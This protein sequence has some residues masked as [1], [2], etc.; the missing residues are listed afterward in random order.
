M[1][2]RHCNPYNSKSNTVNNSANSSGEIIYNSNNSILIFF[3]TPVTLYLRF[4]LVGV[5]LFTHLNN[6]INKE[7]LFSD[8]LR[9]LTF[10][11]AIKIFEFRFSLELSEVYLAIVWQLDLLWE[12]SDLCRDLWMDLLVWSEDLVRGRFLLA[13]IFLFRLL[14]FSLLLA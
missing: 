3:I 1:N 13:S 4:K 5:H 7:D 11:L 9:S 8:P 14:Y 6:Q 10:L 2:K 12:E